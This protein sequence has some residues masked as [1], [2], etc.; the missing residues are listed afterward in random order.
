MSK[1]ERPGM[2]GWYDPDQLARTGVDV[3]IS[4]IFGRESDF[5]ALEAFTTPQGSFFQCCTCKPGEPAWIDYVGDTGDG[6]NSTYSVAYWLAQPKLTVATSDGAAGETTHTG[7]V[8]LFGG[9]QVYPTAN[10]ASYEERLV[11]PYKSARER[12]DEPYPEVYAIPGNHDWYDHLVSFTRLF[13][14]KEWFAG[15][16]T[17]QKRSYFA[18]K[19]PYGWWLVGTDIQLG[20]D[21]D[22]AQ[23]DYFKE[24]AKAMQPNDRIILCTAEPHWIYAHLYRKTEPHYYNEKTLAFLESEKV[25]GDRIQ[26]FLAGDLH[27][28]RR[29]EGEDK[30]QKITSGGGGAFLHPTHGPQVEE[31]HQDLLDQSHD[32]PPPVTRH[33]TY[34]RRASY[35]D[36]K[37]SRNLA[38]QNLLF[39]FRNAKFGKLIASI[40]VLV[41]WTILNDVSREKT[42]L[43]ALGQALSNTVRA[44][45]ATFTV[46]LLLLAFVFFTDTHF[47][48]FRWLGGGFHALLHLSA[49]LFIGWGSALLTI[50]LYPQLA[51]HHTQHMIATG[52]VIWFAGWLVGSLIFGVY[53]LLA[54]NVFRRHT[55][56]AFSSLKIEDYKNFLR[57]RLDP[58]GTMTIF[59]IGVEKVA[60]KWKTSSAAAG[61][62]YD[63]DGDYTKPFLIE[64]PIII[65]PDDLRRPPHNEGDAP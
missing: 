57:F 28:Y 1:A 44:P 53:L 52:I 65:R 40:Y 35:P 50:W 2:V 47:L 19:L 64:E 4:T 8:L 59:P 22:F 24:A 5:R 34:T 32:G 55:N 18:L 63:P 16:R 46:V 48:L 56:E 6:W 38:W 12:S 42:L 9:D 26:I 41:A 14:S 49:I 11:T 3:A 21:I 36:A 43:H 62:K 7:Q 30:R 20:S 15:W 39:P 61:P 31:L 25:F 60:R 45:S 29:H 58:D 13:C 10:R 27:H 17:R 54:L 51:Y 37:T 23:L 33:S